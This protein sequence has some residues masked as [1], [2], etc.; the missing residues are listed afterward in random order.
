MKKIFAI[1]LM[2]ISFTATAQEDD[3][4]DQ[5]VIFDADKNLFPD[6]KPG[7]P[8]DV[9]S[10]KPQAIIMGFFMSVP[11]AMIKDETGS[12]PADMGLTEIK[13]EVIKDAGKELLVFSGIKANGQARFVVEHIFISHSNGTIMIRASYPENEKIKYS[14][15]AKRAALT[16]MVKQ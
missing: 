14:E 2:L 13:K 1:V 3:F 8:G 15:A 9:D 10:A 5:V 4:E 11:Y 6:T 7:E 12:G 16:A